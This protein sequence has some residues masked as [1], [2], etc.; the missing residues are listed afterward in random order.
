MLERNDSGLSVGESL[1]GWYSRGSRRG[2]G[3]GSGNWF[4]GVRGSDSYSPAGDLFPKQHPYFNRCFGCLTPNT[5]PAIA[6]SDEN[7]SRI[8]G[9]AENKKRIRSVE[10]HEA[11]EVRS[12]NTIR[13]RKSWPG[14]TNPRYS[15]LGY[16]TLQAGRQCLA[17][18]DH[19][20]IRAGRLTSRCTSSM[21][22]QCRSATTMIYGENNGGFHYYPQW[23]PCTGRHLPP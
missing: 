15:T 21:H 23:G 6:Y 7:G 3:S 19:V 14:G 11:E 20:W 2:C 17:S 16:V 10:Q 4:G 9:D 8:D 18:P 22:A 5:L 13:R 1:T 12:R